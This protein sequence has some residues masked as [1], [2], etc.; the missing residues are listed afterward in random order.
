MTNR[1]H[2]ISPDLINSGSIDLQALKHYWIVKTG[3]Q[4]ENAECCNCGRY[5][6]SFAAGLCQ[7][8]YNTG[9]DKNGA[10]LLNAL[11]A[12][13]AVLSELDEAAVPPA[14]IVGKV[15]VT[16]PKYSEDFFGS[17]VDKVNTSGS[18]VQSLNEQLTIE[19]APSVDAANNE[20]PGHDISFHGRQ[21]ASG[22]MSV[23]MFKVGAGP[24]KDSLLH[25][26]EPVALSITEELK[27]KLATAQSSSTAALPVSTT[28]LP[29]KTKDITV[30]P[31]IKRSLVIELED[32]ALEFRVGD[33]SIDIRLEDQGEI[34]FE[35]L[36]LS[37]LFINDL[38]IMI[39]RG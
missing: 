38:H 15:E 36:R 35:V 37:P 33:E 34:T 4:G 26:Y 25:V 5:V 16:D 12:K 8:C 22:Q 14:K 1:W 19:Y 32:A 7:A 11:T 23:Y 2:D 39:N 24:L 13:R 28:A 9:K 3:K 17:Q 10:E 29:E 27:R 18:I 20:I 21:D 31:I 6:R 30:K